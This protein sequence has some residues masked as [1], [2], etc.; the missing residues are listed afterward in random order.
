MQRLF[1]I[2][3]ICLCPFLSSGASAEAG[4]EMPPS[5]KHSERWLVVAAREDKQEA[6]QMA[7]EV[8]YFLP[9]TF[10]V[11]AKNG[12]FAIVAGPVELTSMEAVRE[13]EYASALPD[14]AY[15]SKGANYQEVVW[16]SPR[17]VRV[18]L[19]D[20]TSVKAQL[21]SLM[22]EAVRQD[23]EGAPSTGE[24][25]V[26]TRLE[27]TLR[28]VNGTLLQTLPTP[29]DAYASFG[30]SLELVRIS[31]ETP[32]PQVLIRRFTGGAH[33]CFQTSI[34]TSADGNSWDLVEAGNF[35]AGADYR[36]VDLNFDGALELLTIDQT[37]LYLF[38]PYAASF[39]P[40]EVHELV[41][42]KIVNVS[43]QA[44]YRA[45]FVNEL[46]DLEG[47]AEESP[48]LWEMN[49]FLA[50]WGAIKTRLGDFVPALAKITQRHGP[51]HDFGVRVCPD[52]SNIDKCSY[53][54]AVL[55]PF[56]AGFTLHLVEQGYLTGDPYRTA[57]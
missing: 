57:Q 56:P 17:I 28:D 20:S 24:D 14:D 2:M 50:A 48:D 19:D 9:Q 40:P 31:P 49:G 10:V 4:R 11:H 13:K 26:Q 8:S 37:F 52:G 39:A 46:R 36:L 25:Y 44:D 29:L 43:A 15:L 7:R 33:C 41:G 23:A 5:L 21:E 53:E 45:E 51:A 27:I 3:L 32:Y 18:D 54:E 6:I 47:M 22:V 16:S 12:W 42:S 1:L 34:L 30:N 38:A 55:L 35:D